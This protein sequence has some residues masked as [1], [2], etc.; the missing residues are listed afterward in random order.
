MLK[1]NAFLTSAMTGELDEERRAIRILFNKSSELS[2]F[3]DLYAIEEHASPLGIEAD[4][5]DNVVHSQV[6]ISVLKWKLRRPVEQE[7]NIAQENHLRIFCYVSNDDRQ[8]DETMIKFIREK[9]HDVHCGSYTS[10]VDLVERIERDLLDDLI[11]YYAKGFRD[12]GA[13]DK[14]RYKISVSGGPRSE[15]RFFALH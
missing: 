12:R 4:F 3:Y 9:A 6:L 1:I 11:R 5:S 13:D 7:F 2:K 10:S 8:R 15:Y 14:E